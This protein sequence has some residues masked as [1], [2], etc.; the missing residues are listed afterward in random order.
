[1]LTHKETVS[2]IAWKIV[3]GR[4]LT[5]PEFKLALE[6]GMIGGGVPK[7]DEALAR[8][9][10]YWMSQYYEDDVRYAMLCSKHPTRVIK[11]E[12]GK[13][14]CCAWGIHMNEVKPDKL[15]RNNIK[16]LRHAFGKAK[17]KELT[18]K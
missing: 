11:E 15:T 16:F 2:E 1:M 18:G 4:K 10:I 5:L 3:G 6:D 8:D 7:T 12:A 13:K 9:Y 14:T 17:V